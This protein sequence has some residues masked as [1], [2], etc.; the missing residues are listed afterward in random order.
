M[1]HNT[2]ANDAF[3]PVLLLFKIV[4]SA[5]CLYIFGGGG[6]FIILLHTLMPYDKKMLQNIATTYVTILSILG[7]WVF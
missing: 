4:V 1:L 6:S 5:V 2:A 3:F 7:I